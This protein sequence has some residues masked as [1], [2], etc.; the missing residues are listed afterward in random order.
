[1]I[2]FSK[3]VVPTS[4][5]RFFAEEIR[6]FLMSGEIRKFEEEK[7]FRKKSLVIFLKASMRK[8]RERKDTVGS[9][10]PGFVSTKLVFV[11][12]LPYSLTR[13]SS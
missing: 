8:L 5:V 1:M 2:S 6:K 10:S 4:F 3:I 11:S 9:R 7:V 13:I 12:N